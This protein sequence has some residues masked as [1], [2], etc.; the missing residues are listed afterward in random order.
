VGNE[1]YGSWETDNN[2]R[3]HDPYTYAQR[4]AQYYSQMKAVDPA[5]KVGAVAVTGEDSYANYTD[6]P[7]L[8]PRTGVTHNGWTPVM[9]TT[10]RGLGV[11]P[12]FLIYHRYP[13]APGRKMTRG[14]C[15]PPAPGPVTRPTCA[16]SSMIT[17]ARRQRKLSWTAPKTTQFTPTPANRRPV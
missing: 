9:L 10:L 16:S 15:F 8:N 4:F 13:E 3:P 11:T 5:I 1:V 14:C 7:A 6:H 2:T 17:W 12:D